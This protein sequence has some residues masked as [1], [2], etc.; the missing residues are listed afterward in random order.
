MKVKAPYESGL[1]PHLNAHALPCPPAFR[2]SPFQPLAAAHPGIDWNELSY[3]VMW[4]VAEAQ[5][6]CGMSA[7]VD[8]P[9]ARRPLFDRAAALAQQYGARLALVELEPIDPIVW[10]ERIEARGRAVQGTDQEHKPGSWAEV[11]AYAARSADSEGWSAEVEVQLHC[12][13]DSTASSRDAQL[14][15]VLSM[16]G[17]A[18][19]AAGAAAAVGLQQEQQRGV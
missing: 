10:R 19:A 11:Q 7:V 18:G 12:R 16:L 9:L 4:R 14:A 1:P 8:C 17:Q 5:L 6:R 15:A 2:C 13:L 3:A